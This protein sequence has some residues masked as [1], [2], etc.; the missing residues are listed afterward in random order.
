[1]RQRWMEDGVLSPLICTSISNLIRV[2]CYGTDVAEVESVSGVQF[3][4]RYGNCGLGL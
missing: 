3:Y 2:G 4:R 1:M